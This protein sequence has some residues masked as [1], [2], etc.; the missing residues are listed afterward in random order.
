MLDQIDTGRNISSAT[1]TTSRIDGN[2][3]LWKQL[4]KG[5]SSDGYPIRFSYQ[6]PIGSYSQDGIGNADRDIQD[7]GEKSVFSYYRI[8][9]WQWQ[10]ITSGLQPRRDHH[11]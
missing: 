3:P 6:V 4:G 10:D 8:R 7:P 1:N 5:Q 9:A 2:S 11:A